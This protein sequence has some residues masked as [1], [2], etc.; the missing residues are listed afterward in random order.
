MKLFNISK[1]SSCILYKNNHVSNIYEA[2][3]CCY[4]NTKSLSYLD[5]K[6]YIKKRIDS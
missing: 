6:K 3:T 5:K 4:D 2:C 1:I